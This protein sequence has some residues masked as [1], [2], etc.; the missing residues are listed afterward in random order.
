MVCGFAYTSLGSSR[1]RLAYGGTP[2]ATA[3][4]SLSFLCARS[5][6]FSLSLSLFRSLRQPYRAR[7]PFNSS[8]ASRMHRGC[9]CSPLSET[10]ARRD[11]TSGSPSAKTRGARALQ[12][13]RARYIS[14]HGGRG[15]EG[16]DV[17]RRCSAC[18]RCSAAPH[19]PAP[20]NARALDR[21]YGRD[22]RAVSAFFIV[23]F[24][25]R[26][27]GVFYSRKLGVFPP[28][29]SLISISFSTAIA[30]AAIAIFFLS[31]LFGLI[32]ENKKYLHNRIECSYLRSNK[33]QHA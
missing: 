26:N 24:I 1:L 2:I 11:D 33:M 19:R 18:P 28:R 10:W 17:T 7:A 3:S 21:I 12:R 6:S 5:F 9:R 30:R 13:E 29:R 14:D 23:T 8:G 31:I 27:R 4:F 32:L 20:P 15:R 16:A 22:S 25:R